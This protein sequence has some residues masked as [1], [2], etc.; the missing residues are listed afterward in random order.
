MLDW[1]MIPGARKSRYGTPAVGI[2]WSRLKVSPKMTSQSTGWIARVTASVRS[3]ESFCSSTRQNVATRLGNCRQSRGSGSATGALA[4]PA[5]RAP[6]AADRADRGPGLAAIVELVAGVVPEHVLERRARPERAL[7][8]LRGADGDDA[9]E[10]E[11]RDPVAE[12]VRL[13]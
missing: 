9:A 3:C 13:L 12:E 7:Q 4:K 11:E 8:L 2:A 5:R 10:V 1:A 6:R